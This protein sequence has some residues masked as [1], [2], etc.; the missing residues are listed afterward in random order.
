MKKFKEFRKELP[1]IDEGV[2]IKKAL[3]KV[4]GLTKK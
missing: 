3:N 4:K 2:D 1:E